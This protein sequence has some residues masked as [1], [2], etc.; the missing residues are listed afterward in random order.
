VGGCGMVEEVL[1]AL[2]R[3][4]ASL[5]AEGLSV[6]EDV[7]QLVEAEESVRWLSAWAEVVRPLLWLRVLE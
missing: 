6:L 4:G 3:M 2:K 5:G 1:L 7:A